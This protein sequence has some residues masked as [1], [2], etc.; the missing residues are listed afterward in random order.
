M[1]AGPFLAAYGLTFLAELPDKTAL[2][3]VMLAARRDKRAVL[4]GAMSALALQAA[5][6]AS[7]G[8]ALARLPRG[9]VRYA[10][11]AL[12][13]VLAVKLWLEKEE[14]EEAGPAGAGGRFW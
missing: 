9:P 12:F 5:L 6:A 1:S 8:G 4:A 10:A 7:L 2:A 13:A 14:E 11:A 3:T